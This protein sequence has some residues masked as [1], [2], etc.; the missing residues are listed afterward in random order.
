MLVDLNTIA[1]DEVPDDP[2]APELKLVLMALKIVFRKD[3]GTK[4]NEILEE[5][6]SVDPVLQ[7]TVRMVWYYF[8]ASAEH[9]ERDFNILYDTIK[10]IVEVE[11]MPTMLEKWTADA[12]A[13]GEA[14]G[15]AKGKAEGKA[16][17]GRR[18]VLTALQTKFTRVPKDIEKMVLT[19]SDPIALE[20]LLEQAIQCDT[21]DEFAEGLR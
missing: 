20:S 7:E 3:A 5:L 14:I 19:M 1:D 6:G 2:D 17:A 8:F 12:V 9:M 16:E 4:I 18:M 10:K 15:E 13:K 21:M 11:T